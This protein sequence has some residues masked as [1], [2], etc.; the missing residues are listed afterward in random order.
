MAA[1]DDCVGR[2][3]HG[4]LE[5][6]QW[7][8]GHDRHDER[9]G[10]RRAV[11]RRALDDAS[12]DDG[13]ARSSAPALI[14]GIALG[15]VVAAAAVLAVVLHRNGHARGDDFALYLR[16]ARSLFDGNIGQVVADN[17]F[18]VINSTGRLQPVRI[19]VGTPA[20]AGS[21]RAPVGPRL[22]PL[23]AGRGGGILRVARA[24]PRYRAPTSRPCPRSRGHRRHGDRTGVLQPHRSAAVGVPARGR[25]R[26]GHLVARPDADARVAW[27]APPSAIW[28]CSG[29]RDGRL[30]LPARSESCCSASSAWCNSSSSPCTSVDERFVSLPWRNLAIPY[31]A[32]AGSAIGFQLLLPSM[33]FPDNG[34]N[35]GYIDDRF[36]GYPRVLT[37]QIGLGSHPAIGA[38]IVGLA[39]VGAVIGIRKRPGLDGPLAAVTVLS[40]DRRQHPFPDGRSVLLPDHARGCSTSRRSR[41][42]AAVAPRVARSRPA[43]HRRLR[44]DAAAV[45][46]RRPRGGP[47]GR[48]QARSRTSIGASEQPIGTDR[49]TRHARLRRRRP[50]HPARR[51][52]RLLPGAHDDAVHRPAGDPDAARRPH[53]PTRRLLR[54]TPRVGLLPA[55]DDRGPRPRPR[56]RDRLVRR[57]LDPLE[58]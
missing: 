3:G 17:R 38:L 53:P 31:V 14:H 57:P 7:R 12:A 42:L 46:R 37:Q 49:S 4:P 51:H 1:T 24:R 26:R 47:A 8:D 36:G 44:R 18:T 9:D 43:S 5:Q 27:S 48:H 11:R 16:Q 19:S 50:P 41:S 35:A 13:D 52:H 56:F 20:A 29:P 33:L 6:P 28:W 58:G 30:Q 40:A 22:R 2:G 25:R 15:V 55:E 45:P 21:V 34:D 23:E 39:V 32:F 54:P 10:G